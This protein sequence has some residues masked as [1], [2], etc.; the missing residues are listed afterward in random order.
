MEG[1]EYHLCRLEKRT[2][3]CVWLSCA[4]L[5][6]SALCKLIRASGSARILAES[7]PLFGISNR[8]LF[9][10]V[11]LL[12]IW[13]AVLL[14]GRH[15]L[16][17][18][19]LLIAGLATNFVVYRAGLFYLGVHKPCPCLGNALEWT[20]VNVRTLDL[21]MTGVLLWLLSTSFIPLFLLFWCRKSN[22]LQP[23]VRA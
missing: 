10:L 3:S 14:A 23:E 21:A 9:L 15:T 12:E 2:K 17:V 11:G 16:Y 5:T 1:V 8:D 4:I 7:D 13:L 19:L 18:K 6:V 22:P 20:H